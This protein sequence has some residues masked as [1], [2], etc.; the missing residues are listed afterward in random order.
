MHPNIKA[1]RQALSETGM[2]FE[3]VHGF[4]N[5]VMVS[6][7]PFMYGLTPFNTQSASMVSIDKAIS[8]LVPIHGGL[9]EGELYV[10]AGSFILKAELGKGSAAHQ[11]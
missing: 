8:G 3:P 2:A 4:D 6:G 7:H 9:V 5:A 11:H 1:L 10:A